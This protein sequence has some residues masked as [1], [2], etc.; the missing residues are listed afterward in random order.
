MVIMI[1]KD[2]IADVNVFDEEAINMIRDDTKW[3]VRQANIAVRRQRLQLLEKHPRAIYGSDPTIIFV[4][5]WTY[6]S[7]EGVQEIPFMH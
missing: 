5:E 7:E 6:I 1:D 4:I 3:L 2:I